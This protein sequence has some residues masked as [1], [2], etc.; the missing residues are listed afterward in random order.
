MNTVYRDSSNRQ[1]ILLE[2]SS[3]LWKAPEDVQGSVIL[4]MEPRAVRNCVSDFFFK[5]LWA[6]L[7]IKSGKASDLGQSVGRET[8]LVR[9]SSV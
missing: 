2:A 6:K 7:D 8:I 9:V 4:R 1:D 3:F 5:S